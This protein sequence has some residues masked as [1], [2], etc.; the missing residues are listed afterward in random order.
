MTEIDWK[1]CPRCKKRDREI[2]SINGYMEIYCDS[3]NDTLAE[4]YRE[5]KEF[6]YWHD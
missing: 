6:E 2:C 1:L 4:A 5:R 3:C